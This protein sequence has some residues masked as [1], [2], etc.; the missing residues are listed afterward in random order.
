MLV[1]P[2]RAQAIALYHEM[3]ACAPAAAASAPACIDLIGGH[4]GYNGGPVLA[5][6]TGERTVVAVGAGERG[7]LE[8]VVSGDR[9]REKLDLVEGAPAGW[10]AAVGGVLRE[11]AAFG[12]VPEG[13]RIAVASDIPRHAG[14]ASLA[15]TAALAVASAKA[16]A[17]LMRVS[18]TARKLAGVAFRAG[19]DHGQG[20]HGVMEYTGAALAHAREAL[21]IEC[22]SAETRRVPLGGRVLLV[23]TGAP[24][25][26][27][28][29]T[30]AQRRSECEAAVL[31]LK[32]DLPELLW[33]ASWPAA[34]LVRLK[35]ALPQP[36]RS[37]AVHVVSETARTRFAAELLGTGRLKRFGELLYESHE[38][39]RRSFDFSTP[40][41]DL[42]VSAAQ[43][44]GALGARLAR[45]GDTGTVVVLLGK[46]DGER[47][48]G[49]AKISESIQRAYAKAFGHEVAITPV[50]SGEGARVEPV[51]PLR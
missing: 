47:G 42:V 37:R 19:P 9:R 12:A 24:R 35:R 31:R 6:A 1:K 29:A 28:D 33:L 38:S 17:G 20:R 10:L 50:L 25:G 8:A 39:C 48:K 27:L 15:A 3:F 36:V 51:R 21:L 7:T 49:E 14:L 18:L 43:R 22:A 5:I 16:L 4:T 11:L 46:G 40:Q 23:E 34:W 32:M 44:A 2:L 30:L 26:E 13:V 45:D 41:A